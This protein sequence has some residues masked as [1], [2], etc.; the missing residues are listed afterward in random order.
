M[1]VDFDSLTNIIEQYGYLA[2]FLSMTLEGMCIPVPSELV[3]GFAGFMVY[4][5][6]FS[7]P[8]AI[9]AGWL[10]SMTGS[11]FIYFLARQGG[12]EF[13]YKFCR[14]IHLSPSYVDK[15]SD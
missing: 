8:G 1:A 12:R 5:N 11:L 14:L 9:L 3:L 4:Q 2:V 13:L 7:F 15:M 6:V 10:G